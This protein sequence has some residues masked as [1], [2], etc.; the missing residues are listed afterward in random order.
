MHYT[1]RRLRT[2][3][4]IDTETTAAVDRLTALVDGQDELV[5]QFKTE[6][7]LL[8]NSLS[9]F[10]GFGVHSISPDL[11]PAISAAAA[12]ILHLTLDTSSAAARDVRECLDDLDH[13]ASQTRQGRSVEALL[14]HGRLP[15]T[16]LPSVDNTLNTIRALSQKRDQ[17]ALRA[18]ILERQVASRASA[19]WFRRLLY[20]TPLLLVMFLVNLGIRL[21]SRGNALQ[22]R[23]ALEHVIARISM[24]F[25][26]AR[27]Q[28][29]DAGID[30]AMA[31][32]AAYNSSDRVYLVM[33]GPKP[34]SY[35][36]HLPGMSPPPGWPDRAPELAAR[37]GP[38]LTAWSISPVRIACRQER[39]RT[40]RKSSALGVGM[41]DQYRPPGAGG[42]TRF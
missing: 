2:I 33:S 19:R 12:A 4:A 9:I 6:N 27:P 20:G 23:A 36:W 18:M 21:K 24:R 22:R 7:A 40:S 32:L 38:A 41:R 29:I 39:T 42:R 10:G 11:D 31:D 37:I 34:R 14:A 28:D 26:N 3:P 5:E 13:Q 15:H 16:L 8:H 35:V 1:P 17:D 25:I 30:R